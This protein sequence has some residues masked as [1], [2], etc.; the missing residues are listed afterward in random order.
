VNLKEALAA[1]MKQELFNIARVQ[2]QY[3]RELG[4]IKKVVSSAA[5]ARY[6]HILSLEKDEVEK[7]KFIEKMRDRA[8]VERFNDIFRDMETVV[9]D[10]TYLTQGKYPT[11][12]IGKVVAP[13]S[14]IVWFL[15]TGE[16]PEKLVHID[17]DHSNTRFSNLKPYVKGSSVTMKKYPCRITVGDEVHYIGTFDSA[18]ERDQ[19]KARYCLEKGV[20]IPKPG[21]P[22]GSTTR[23]PA[24][25]SL[26]KPYQAV[27][28]MNG[29]Q[30]HLGRYDTRDEVRK[31]RE[32]FRERHGK[33]KGGATFEKP[34]AVAQ[35]APAWMAAAPLTP[36]Q[37]TTSQELPEWMR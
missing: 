21:R 36:Q 35:E 11:L 23:Q 30:Y 3:D 34:A 31:A 27:V 13:V 28:L 2:L 17:G 16:A 12:R 14:H 18:E 24:Q 7:K 8:E 29:R 9:E 19:A 22:A 25:G 10:A 4:Q 26:M 33:G 37:P 15:E 20:P 5:L 32:A 1:G 6:N